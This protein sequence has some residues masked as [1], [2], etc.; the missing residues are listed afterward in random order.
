MVF[1]I[2]TGFR[3]CR[4]QIVRMTELYIRSINKLKDRMFFV[5]ISEQNKNEIIME[6]GLRI[7][8]IDSEEEEES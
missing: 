8:I 1:K 3:V 7:V 2:D 6:T 4:E 5:Q